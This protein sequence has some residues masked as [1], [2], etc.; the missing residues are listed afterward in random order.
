MPAGEYTAVLLP[1]L[2]RALRAHLL[3]DLSGQEER[4][5]ADANVDRGRSARRTPSARSGA[6][7]W[8]RQS[9]VIAIS[10]V[11]KVDPPEHYC[12]GDRM[13]FEDTFKVRN[14]F[15]SAGNRISYQRQFG[16]DREA[17]GL[18]GVQRMAR[19]NSLFAAKADGSGFVDVSEQAGVTMGRW[20]WSSGFVDMDNDGWQDLVIANGYLTNTRDVDL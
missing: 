10:A 12:D 8:S 11:L 5:E 17:S 18:A 6:R 2:R 14:M 3:S 4:D 13:R 9:V 19:G 15:S 16:G 1:K 20:A 7:S